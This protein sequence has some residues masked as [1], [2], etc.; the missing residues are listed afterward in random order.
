[1]P[2][3][4]VVRMCGSVILLLLL[5]LLLYCALFHVVLLWLSAVMLLV[6]GVGLCCMCIYVLSCSVVALY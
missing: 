1:M 2:C 6:V 5:L 3:S 4:F